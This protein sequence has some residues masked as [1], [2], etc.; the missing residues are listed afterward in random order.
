MLIRTCGGPKYKARIGRFAAEGPSVSVVLRF[1]LESKDFQAFQRYWA[2]RTAKSRGWRQNL[3]RFAIVLVLVG[4]VFYFAE[5]LMALDLSKLMLY[6]GL[7]IL[8]LLILGSFSHRMGIRRMAR[9]FSGAQSVNIDDVGLC[10]GDDDTQMITR[11]GAIEEV[12][13]TRHHIFIVYGY[14]KSVIVPKRAFDTEGAQATFLA[15]LRRYRP[16]ILVETPQAFTKRVGKGRRRAAIATTVL[17]LLVGLWLW[18]PWRSSVT[19]ADT[20]ERIYYLVVHTGN[21]DPAA[22]LP[23]VLDLHPLGGSP[24][25]GRFMLRATDRPARVILPAGDGWYGIGYSWFDFDVDSE[26]L[27][28]NVRRASTRLAAFT[29]LM[30]AHYPTSGKPIV[31]GFSQG[32]S[33]SYALAQHYPGLFAAAV[34]VSGAFAETLP[35]LATPPNIKVR[36]FHGGSDEIVLEEWAAFGI[37][38]MRDQGWDVEY[39]VYP[40][41]GHAIGSEAKDAWS[42]VLRALIDEQAGR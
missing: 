19:L 34:P 6:V 35:V 21:A 11:W 10:H 22:T 32:G 16:E 30:Q 25:I 39:T 17:L 3:F 12:T 7:P 36:A 18:K 26:E 1:T 28:G 29:K 38:D 13:Q 23:L 31:T 42:A 20:G 4:L 40:D 9:S 37:D 27:V 33:M 14:G 8:I 2:E 41:R 15:S 24:E 5:K